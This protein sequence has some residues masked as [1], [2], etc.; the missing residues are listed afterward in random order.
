MLKID[1][2]KRLRQE[3]ADLKQKIDLGH[4]ENEES[5]LLLKRKHQE[6]I[7]E[8]SAHIEQLSKTKFKFE[9][10]NKSFLLQLDELRKDND[11]MAR[12]KVIV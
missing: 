1:A 5:T 10:E 11:N 8:L 2:S 9:K 6:Q 3:I 7:N 12:T 4:S